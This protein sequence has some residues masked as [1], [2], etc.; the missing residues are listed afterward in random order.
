MVTP[1]NVLWVLNLIFLAGAVG[2]LLSRWYEKRAQVYLNACELP[3]LPDLTSFFTH[4][5][6]DFSAKYK[7]LPILGHFTWFAAVSRQASLEWL[8]R[9]TD[10]HQGRSWKLKLPLI[11]QAWVLEDPA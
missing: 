2:L 10:Y 1:T 6:Y 11:G 8:K 3:L 4:S 9:A 7:P 5:M